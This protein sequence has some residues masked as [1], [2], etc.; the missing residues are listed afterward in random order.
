MGKIC[1]YVCLDATKKSMNLS[2]SARVP[3]PVALG[4]EVMCNK[5]PLDLIFHLLLLFCSAQLAHS[6]PCYGI[7]AF[8]AILCNT[9]FAIFI[10]ILLNIPKKLQFWHAKGKK[11]SLRWRRLTFE[12]V[13]CKTAFPNLQRDLTW[14]WSFWVVDDL[15]FELVWLCSV[16]FWYKFFGWL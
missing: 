4:K 8:S 14:V 13:L 1:Q 12:N 10:I 16:L 7:L 6:N 3:T 5:M 11:V 15:N 9:F 2:T